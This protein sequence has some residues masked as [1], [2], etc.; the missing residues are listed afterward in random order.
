MNT[1]QTIIDL[2]YLEMMADGDDFMKKTMLDMLLEELPSE[3]EKM[4]E[5]F[6]AR[7][8]DQLHQVAHKMKSTLAFVGN[9]SMTVAN[10]GIERIGKEASSLQRAA[11]PL[12][13]L[14]A[15]AQAVME[16]LAAESERLA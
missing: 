12:A 1:V 4:R 8:A 16:A 9:D 5:A 2:S 7:D 3:L 11:T 10:A 13:T 15:T 14:E 6:V